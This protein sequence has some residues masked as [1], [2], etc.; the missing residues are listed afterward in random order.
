[1]ALFMKM[2]NYFFVIFLFIVSN[3]VSAKCLSDP[4]FSDEC[5]FP[6]GDA[7]CAEQRGGNPYAYS[8]NCLKQRQTVSPEQANHADSSKKDI[9][10]GRC[11]MNS[12]SW[13]KTLNKNAI[14]DNRC[15]RLIQLELLGGESENEAD[16]DLSTIQWNTATHIVYLFCSKYL[17]SVIMETDSQYQVDV[18]D[19]WNG[20][21]GFLESSASLYRE[22][23]HPGSENLSE[24]DLAKK[25]QYQ[26]IPDA[27]VTVNQ[28]LE[29]VGVAQSQ[30][31]CQSQLSFTN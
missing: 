30:F 11:H 10:L 15:G 23:C 29:I 4:R 13:S 21:P 27:E 5:R 31:N 12:C 28:P 2:Q 3:T 22:H 25:Y 1:M 7:W 26:Q 20:V 19:F 16:L 17:P 8:D 18:L 9:S 14:A 24:E 6:K